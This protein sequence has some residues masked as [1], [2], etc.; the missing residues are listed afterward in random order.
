VAGDLLYV[1]SLD[2]IVEEATDLIQDS[3]PGMPSNAL[4]IRFSGGARWI[5]EKS[6]LH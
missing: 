1:N 2:D 3:A 6:S 4:Q 5:T